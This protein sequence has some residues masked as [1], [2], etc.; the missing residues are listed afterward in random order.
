MVDTSNAKIIVVVKFRSP[1]SADE[2]KRRYQ[3]RM[4]EFRKQP[5]LIQ[6]YYV[7]EESSG[8]WAG[9]YLWDSKESVE[10]YLASDLR[11]SIA[12][13]YEVEGAPR[14]ETFSLLEPLRS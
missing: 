7:R 12:S 6:K 9:I 10:R 8:E 4:P 11:K 13:A 5:G 3:E 1:L 14:I 2:L